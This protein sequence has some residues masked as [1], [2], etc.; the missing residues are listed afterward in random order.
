MIELK[1]E[2]KFAEPVVAYYEKHGYGVV[3]DKKHSGVQICR[4]TK[5]ALRG[6]RHCYKAWFGIKSHRCVQMTPTLDFCNLSCSH[7]WRSFGQYRDKAANQWDAPKTI[8][9]QAILAQQKLLSGFGGNPA[10]TA[11]R[12]DEAN[13]P[14]HFAI[15]LD[16]EPTL[17]PHIAG[18]IKEVR[19]RGCT[20]FLVTNGTLPHRLKE[21]L[22][23]KAIPNNL[24]IS[25]YG[26]NQEMFEE[27]TNARQ[28]QLW[29]KVL[30]S[31]KLFPAFEKYECRTIFRITATKN[32]SLQNAEGYAKLVDLSK[33]MFVEL[34]GY[35]WMGDS[36]RRLST[37]NVPTVED[38]EAFAQELATRTG[39]I[40][41]GRDKTSRVIL[42]IRE[43]KIWQWNLQKIKEQENVAVEL[44]RSS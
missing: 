24:Y 18:L 29:S 39:Y 3:G 10:T 27:I 2:Q 21:M 42:L 34:K 5:S 13:D 38:L 11:K 20:A 35:A 32:L 31:I 25:V 15:S 44:R 8:V 41:K 19:S 28:P 26:A 9:D 14:V 33:P 30:E 23:K 4:F 16:G 36:K 37:D 40:I 1:L 12:I 6:K 17:Y 43:P 22:A 7:C